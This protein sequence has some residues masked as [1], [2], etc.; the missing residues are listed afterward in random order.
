MLLKN[1]GDRKPQNPIF[2]VKELKISLSGKT[3]PI[4]KKRLV[5]GA[6]Y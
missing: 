5:C 4:T 3:L 2:W 6:I 1:Y